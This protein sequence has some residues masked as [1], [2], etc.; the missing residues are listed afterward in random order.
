MQLM[1]SELGSIHNIL[2][3]SLVLSPRHSA[4]SSGWGNQCPGL[5]SEQVVSG[6]ASGTEG[7]EAELYSLQRQGPENCEEQL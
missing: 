5:S 1:G 6:L 7:V 4:A 3:S 2:T